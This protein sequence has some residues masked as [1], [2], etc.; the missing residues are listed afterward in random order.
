MEVH[1]KQVCT[2]AQKQQEKNEQEDPNPIQHQQA[3]KLP[4]KVMATLEQLIEMQ[5]SDPTL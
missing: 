4:D 5:K 2:R 1:I 3:F